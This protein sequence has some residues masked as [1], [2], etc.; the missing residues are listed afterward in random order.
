MMDSCIILSFILI[1]SLFLYKFYKS[2][3]IFPLFLFVIVILIFCAGRPIILNVKNCDAPYY[4]NFYYSAF[5]KKFEEY[6]KIMGGFEYLFYGFLWVCAK[7]NFTYTMTRIIYYL[8]L[9][10]FLVIVIKI[11]DL[12]GLKYSDYWMIVSNCVLSYCLMRNALAYIIGWIAILY[13]LKRKYLLAIV[14]TLIGTMIHNSCVLVLAFIFGFVVF[15][16]IKDFY[17]FLLMAICSYALIITLFPMILLY[18]GQVNGKVAYYIDISSGGSFALLTNLIRFMMLLILLLEY[19]AQYRFK[20]NLQ[21]RNAIFLIVFSYII[22]FAQLVNG[23]IYRF[24]PYFNITNMVVFSFLRQNDEDRLKI[25]V[26][27]V[28]IK[29][30]FILFVNIITLILFIKRDLNGYGLIPIFE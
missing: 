7:L 25:R 28:M 21:Y 4:E 14:Y 5:D 29:N 3:K 2:K 30:I 22:V 15:N 20:D 1:E 23:I 24:L 8:I 6:M 12:E 26:R 13:C 17:F 9:S 10:F 27:S 11:S 16:L 18:L 19:Q